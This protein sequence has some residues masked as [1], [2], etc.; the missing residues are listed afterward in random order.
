MKYIYSFILLIFIAFLVFINQNKSHQFSGKKE[1]LLELSLKGIQDYTQY[2]VL[3]IK[4]FFQ[5]PL[6]LPSPNH[7]TLEKLHETGLHLASRLAILKN[8]D[9]LTDDPTLIRQGKYGFWKIVRVSLLKN[10]KEK[11]NILLE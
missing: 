5:Y 10:W 4:N 6:F 8:I 2:S 7:N 11:I 1:P 9:T 3:E